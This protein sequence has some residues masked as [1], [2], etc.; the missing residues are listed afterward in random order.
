MKKF[1]VRLLIAV[2]I[3]IGGISAQQD[4]KTVLNGKTFPTIVSPAWVGD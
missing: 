3:A 1:L 4:N 2:L